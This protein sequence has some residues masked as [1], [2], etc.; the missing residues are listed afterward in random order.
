MPYG[1]TSAHILAGTAF[2]TRCGYCRRKCSTVSMAFISTQARANLRPRGPFGISQPMI[3]HSQ[4]GMLRSGSPPAA[5]STFFRKPLTA[6]TR[7]PAAARFGNL[8]CVSQQVEQL[9]AALVARQQPLF[10]LTAHVT[11]RDIRS[12]LV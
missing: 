2:F 3:C 6:P 10:A 1:L 11:H 5:S 9:L 4:F 8:D 12:T 7:L